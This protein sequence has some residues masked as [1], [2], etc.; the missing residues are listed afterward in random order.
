MIENIPTKPRIELPIN[1]AGS[2]AKIS[3][4]LQELALP[5]SISFNDATGD[6][7]VMVGDVKVTNSRLPIAVQMVVNQIN[8]GE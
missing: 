6:F 4:G 1:A 2:L 8:N 7:C 3:Q 5:M